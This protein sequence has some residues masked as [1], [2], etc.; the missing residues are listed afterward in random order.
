MSKFI[1]NETNYVD[2]INVNP[3]LPQ[4]LQNTT[5]LKATKCISTK[6]LY[7]IGNIQMGKDSGWY[8]VG[9]REVHGSNP[10]GNH[11]VFPLEM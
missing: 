5:C 4:T 2:F 10:G 1:E 6:C 3:K 9:V 8:G 7:V 11:P